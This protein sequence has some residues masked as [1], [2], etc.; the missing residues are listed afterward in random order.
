MPSDCPHKQQPRQIRARDQQDHRHCQKQHAQQRPRAQHG[1]SLQGIYHRMNPEVCLV[2]R[3]VAHDPMSFAPEE[4][5]P[6]A[7]SSWYL[8]MVGRLNPGVT[9]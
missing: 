9:P 5:S 4:L 1:D 3:V 2:R 8:N 7:E 6:E